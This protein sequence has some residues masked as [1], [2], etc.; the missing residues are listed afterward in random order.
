MDANRK[1]LEKQ[2]EVTLDELA[3]AG[4]EKE[5]E[6]ITK[7]LETLYSLEIEDKKISL[8]E[9]KHKTDNSRGHKIYKWAEV[10]LPIVTTILVFAKGCKFEETGIFTSG[11]FREARQRLFGLIKRK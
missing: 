1:M 11:S 6:A 3:V 5:K 8:D 7:R 4:E 10:T 2:I 9:A